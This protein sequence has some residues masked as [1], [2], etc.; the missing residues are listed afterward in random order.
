V[1]VY[2]IYSLN[3][4]QTDNPH[5]YCRLKRKVKIQKILFKIMLC[6]TDSNVLHL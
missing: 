4:N 1:S 6:C 5:C 2:N 3:I